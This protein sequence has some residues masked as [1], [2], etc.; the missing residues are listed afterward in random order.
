[1]TDEPRATRFEP[2]VE[3]ERVMG[4]LARARRGWRWALGAL[5][6]GLVAS[7]AYLLLRTP[8]YRSQTVLLYTDTIRAAETGEPTTT[9]K[10]VAARL[11][12]ILHSRQEL[13]KVVADYG[14]YPEV[15]KVY[16]TFDAVDE[17]RRHVEFRAPGGDTFSIAFSG[18]SP[19]LARD[20]TAR[21]AEIVVSEDAKLRKKHAASA[22][23]FLAQEKGRAAERLRNAEQELAQ[24][25]ADHPSFALDATPLQSGA[26][27]RARAQAP[28]AARV[29][30]RPRVI[31]LAPEKPSVAPPPPPEPR[32]P[33][34]AE[35]EATRQAKE[36]VGRATA[37]VEAARQYVAE[38]RQRYTDAH[39]DV[40]AAREA[41]SRAEARLLAAR[42]REPAPPEP[43]ETPAP[44]EPKTETKPRY[45]TLP[46]ESGTAARTPAAPKADELVNLETE[47]A[48]LTRVVTEARQRHDQVEAALFKADLAESSAREGPGAEVTVLDPA[49]LPE[50]PVPPGPRTLLALCLAASL[51]LAVGT[52][53]LRALFDDHVYD[54]SSVD[55]LVELLAESPRHAAGREA[56]GRA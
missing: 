17:L 56:H 54:G 4:F 12:E 33:S 2:R 43:A 34:A 37:A 52:A 9:P 51:A 30:P 19:T 53:L 48:R 22:R 28:A 55:D 46:A 24:F 14:L 39:P 20:V 27:I 44:V 50:R 3:L 6:L 40:R 29:P 15:R 13:A 1:M 23:E 5:A 21:L 10:S 38:Q 49:Y 47:W 16:G 8:L 7:G 36:E 11:Q 31:A 32:P 41:L 26:A 35:L 42:A 45:I 18:T 25:M